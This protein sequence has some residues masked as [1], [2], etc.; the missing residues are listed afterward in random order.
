M[1]QPATQET[2]SERGRNI[3]LGAA[4]GL[5]VGGGLDYFLGDTG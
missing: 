2:S 3:A 4:I 5:V 1:K